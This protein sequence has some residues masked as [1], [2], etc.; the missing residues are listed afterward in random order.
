MKEM[1]TDTDVEQAKSKLLEVGIKPPRFWIV[2]GLTMALSF[3]MAVVGVMV[4]QFDGSWSIPVV[5][6]I[7]AG[8][9]F[10]M[11]L[12]FY[13]DMA[14]RYGEAVTMQ[15]ISDGK[16]DPMDAA[17]DALLSYFD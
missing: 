9:G 15:L 1:I 17:R 8:L 5:F 13:V 10:G 4:L 6:L 7:T 12:F 3:G 2:V 11:G 14:S 16:V